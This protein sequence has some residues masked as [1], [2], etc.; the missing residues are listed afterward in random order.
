M[1]LGSGAT[2]RLDANWAGSAANASV[3]SLSGAGNVT[4]GAQTLTLGTNNGTGAHSG[5][6][7]GTGSLIKTGTG[8][9]TLA[10]ANTY[11]GT[12]TVNAGTL[13][14]AMA[15]LRGNLGLGAVTL[16]GEA[17]LSLNRNNSYSV[18]NAISGAG[19]LAQIGTGT[20]TL[21]AANTYTG[22]TTV[23]AGTLR[24][25]G[26]LAASPVT[27]NAGG[28]LGGS[29]T[30]G[31]PVTIASGAALDAGPAAGAAGTL[32]MGALTLNAGSQLSYDLGQPDVV[33]GLNN[34]LVQVNGNLALGGVVN[35]NAAG[36]IFANTLLP[37]S[38]RLINYT[39]T[40]S[41]SAA[42]GSI[43]TGFGA[44]Q[45]QTAVP[46]QVNL[47]AIQNGVPVQF[48]DGADTTGNGIIDGGIGA[49]N[50]ATGNWTN[51]TGSINQSWIPGVGIFTGTAGLVTIAEPVSAM[52]LQFITNGYLVTSA[53]SALTMVALP[54]GSTPFIRVDPGAE[55]DIGAEIAGTDGLL[56]AD[57]GTLILSGTNSYTG[58]TVISEG[59]LQLGNGGSSGSI[60]GSIVNNGFLDFV[61]S[62]TL[63]LGGI[64][65][66]SGTVTQVGT[67][68]TILTATNTYAGG[69]VISGGTLQLG[70]GGATGSVVGDVTDNGA[71]VFDRSGVQSFTGV[72]SG[73]GTV[74]QAGPG[75]TLLTGANTYTGGTLIN[76]GILEVAADGN[77]GAAAGGLNF[78]GGTLQ[79]TASFA[80]ARNA[81][82]GPAGG[83]FQ[84]GANTILTDGGV[85]SGAGALTKT[86]SGTFTLTGASTYAG[87]TTVAAGTLRVNGSLA[88]ASPVTANGGSTL[89]GIGT[90]GGPVTIA[91]GAT[92]DAG[93]AAGAVGTLTMG[94]LTLN[95]GSQLN[96]DLGQPNVIGGPNNDLVQVNG[97]L[98]LGGVVNV[99][100][101]GSI[102]AN[103]LL[104]GS[105]RLI[106]YT[107]ALS[108][109]ASHRQH[110]ERLCGK[111][112]PDGR[113]RPGQP[114][115]RPEWRPGAVLGRRRHD[116]Q[117][118]H[119]WRDQRLEQ[120]RRQL[121]QRDWQHQ[122]E[123]D[124][125]RRDL[126]R[127]G[128]H[129][130]DC[131][132]R[133]RHGAAV[134]HRWLSSDQCGFGADDGG[135]A[136]RQHAVHPRRPGATVDIGAEIAGTA[137]LLKADAGT[138]ILSG[139]NTY[140]GG[141]VISGG[142]LQLGNWRHSGSIVGNVVNNGS[143]DFDRSNTLSFGGVISGS[144]TVTQAGTGTTILTAT[145]TYTGGTVISSGTLQL[146]NGGTG[147][148]IVGDVI[149]N[150]ALVFDRS[151]VQN[152][153]GVISGSGT[154]TQAGTGTTILTGANTYTGTTT[155]AAGTLRVN[156]S[157]AGSA[158]TANGGSTLAASAPWAVR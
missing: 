140:T 34:D 84:V 69:T 14:S 27:A 57:A 116:R 77:L 45:I 103:T 44:S 104:P 101:P 42:I 33:G 88:A 51:A 65:S 72:I 48:W 98:A 16:T 70:N 121:D 108:G 143:L 12:T 64:I 55:V 123:L 130:D 133:E 68:T 63:S 152:F 93:P 85:I 36:S 76:A 13:H 94:A 114:H 53:G 124:T 120:R 19:T 20:T 43:P 40:L 105:Y 1:T 87:A 67:G 47:I 156:G 54:D 58:G 10:G 32:T 83:A 137:G 74:T 31:G 126:H 52:G 112:D 157:L 127:H 9:Q 59:T 39:G 128:G 5:V 129:R 82:L 56:K 60:V 15:A 119:R 109:S 118:H 29:G 61:R 18:G 122:P 62:D 21:T 95:A 146:G 75:T 136:G 25:N 145:N 99:N 7:S 111:P 113:S 46:S 26:S 132:A 30:I 86:G 144:G 110:P 3:K 96:Y 153:T 158:V 38:Y 23:A 71:L 78:N 100:A 115:R 50:N 102:F 66:G 155:V 8:T 81:A 6:I 80:T 49:W 11:T 79:T 148:S 135:A 107:G 131:R 154:V 37:G 28:T 138:L 150:G 92:L 134:H 24:V 141:T 2:L 89:G 4:L 149:D 151:D 117:W 22:A 17:T 35:V 142:T 91:T 106:N 147:G 139:T 90:M 41:G 125:R 97:N 73:S